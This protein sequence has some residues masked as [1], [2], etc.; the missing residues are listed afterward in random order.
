[1][2]QV[3]QGLEGREAREVEDREEDREEEEAED[4]EQDE[5][6]ADEARED[7][8]D[9]EGASRQDEDRRRSRSSHRSGERRHRSIGQRRAPADE[10]GS[11]EREERR[12]GHQRQQQQAPQHPRQQEPPRRYGDDGARV[13]QART[14]P[15]RTDRGAL[16]F[17]GE[18]GLLVR[19]L[20][21]V[22]ELTEVCNK[23][24][25]R[26]Y[27]ATY[28]TDRDSE[29]VFKD[30]AADLRADATWPEFKKALLEHYSVSD[31]SKRYSMASLEELVR[32]QSV[33]GFAR[34]P[35]V[36]DFL[37]EFKMQVAY[38]KRKNV[39]SEGEASRLML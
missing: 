33:K 39:V 31:D 25:R 21:D 23:T 12:Q 7:T 14:M 26:I 1:M 6:T 5:V 17:K 11:L 19:Y 20:E 10:Y 37:R 8:E 18:A 3:Q 35:E 9:E 30:V 27:F 29:L 24:R 22:E 16:S 34:N 2:A 36:V 32:L 38:V 15:L 4:Q 28:F 13:A